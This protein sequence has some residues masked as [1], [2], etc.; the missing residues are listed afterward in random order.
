MSRFH[1]IVA[2]VARLRA[3]D[4]CPWD[5]EQTPASLRPY[6]IEETYEVLDALSGDDPKAV[7]DEL[8][9]LL[10]QIVLHAQIASEA[11][12]FTVE[13]VI[14]NIV[15]KMVRRHPHVFGDAVA[16]S[17]E[18]VSRQWARIKREEQRA[19]A[20]DASTSALDGIPS[21]LPALHA[22]TRTG[23]R[24]ARVGFDWST[25]TRALAKAR[26]ELTELEEALASGDP[27]RIEHELGDALFAL[28]SV[29]RL[30]D[31]NPE[32]AL[33][34]ALT[35]FGA[36]FRHVEQALRAHDRDMEHATPEELDALWNAAKKAGN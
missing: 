18:E 22:A 36:R 2:V 21:E 34:T 13:D 8:G 32:M 10:L 1:E 15:G 31:Q 16:T 7:C 29:G 27:A 20:P 9:D 28:A 26:E 11:E 19:A 3:P 4:G 12:Q 33:R 30:A 24:A 5:R 25:A 35:R 17:A 23:E 6:L 14:A